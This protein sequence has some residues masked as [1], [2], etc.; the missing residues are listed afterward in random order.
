M[1]ASTF[2]RGRPVYP[3]GSFAPNRGQV[4]AQG[5]Q[6][7]LQRELKKG[8]YGGVSQVGS[9][10]RSDTRSGVAASALQRRRPGGKP[11]GPGGRPQGSNPPAST[12][13]GVM[14]HPSTQQPLPS[15]N[16]GG[17]QQPQVPQAPQPPQVV[18]TPTG[19]LELPTTGQFSQ[20]VLAALDQYNSDLIGLNMDEQSEGMEY[21]KNRRDTDI[22]YDDTKRSTLSNNASRGT[23]FSSGYGVAVSRNARDYQNMI[24]DQDT[25]H[26]LFNQMS[27]LKRSSILTAF[28]RMLAQSAMNNA[29]D[30]SGDAGNL[31]LGEPET[32]PLPTLPPLGGNPGGGPHTGGPRPPIRNGGGRGGSGQ[33]N[34]P[35]G[36]GKK[37][38]PKP[39]KNGGKKK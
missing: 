13:S 23:A 12:V 30:L 32:P 34:G 33:G 35:R 20:D 24:N 28:Q 37:H 6:G 27:S 31:G 10:G 38:P 3:G 14:P 25:K 4:S 2:S 8:P 11:Q 17:S 36:G 7:Y 22:K 16:N 15:N 5:A 29:N 19:Q 39:P 9:D 21:T 18:I 26:N 1:S